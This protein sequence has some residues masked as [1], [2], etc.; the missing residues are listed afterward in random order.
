MKNAMKKLMSLLLVALLLVGVMPFGASAVEPGNVS[1][2]VKVGDSNEAVFAKEGTISG[3]STTVK[4]LLTY[5]Y[6]SAD[7]SATYNVGGDAGSYTNPA[8]GAS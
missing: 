7:A 6:G 4:N 5:W 2:A 8:L 3:E 1:F